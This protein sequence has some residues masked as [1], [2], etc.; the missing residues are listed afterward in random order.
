MRYARQT[1]LPQ[2]GEEGQRRLSEAS[3]LIVGLGGLGAPVSTYLAA[4]GVGHLG[5]IDGDRVDSSNLQRQILYCEDWV[6]ESKAQCAARRLRSINSGVE[7]MA[8]DCRLTADNARHMV[9]GYDL[10]IDCTDNFAARLLI[11]KV[12]FEAGLPWVHGSIEGFRGMVTIFNHK[13][14]KRYA[15]LFPDI[16]SGSSPE[17]GKGVIGPTAGT[18]GCIMASEAVKLLSGAADCSLLDGS[19]LHIDLQN[20]IFQ[21]FNF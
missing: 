11:D 17:T 4:G 3:V 20:N 19:F 14:G 6:G 5:I 8:N 15:D 1:M 18:V 9:E 7:V 16:A 2:I 13:A 12:C 21:T 10:V